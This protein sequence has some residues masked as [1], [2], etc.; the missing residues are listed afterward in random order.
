MTKK[1]LI[2]GKNSY[3]GRSF[4]EYCARN[5]IDFD[6][7]EL[8]VHGDDWKQVGFSRF[9]SVFHVAGI[10]HNS[11][12]S[13]LKD[14]YY[15]VNRDLTIAIAEKAKQDG[16][17]QFIFM[18]SMI[19]FGNQPNGKT[20]ITADTEPNPDNFYGDSKLQAERGLQE[21]ESDEFKV[22]VLRPPMIYGEG[23]KGNYPLLSKFAQ[24]SPVFPDYPNK[25]S[26]LYIDNLCEFVK[27]MILNEENGTFHPQNKELVQTSEMV[28]LIA[29]HH[30][31]RIW[32]T[33]LGNPLIR[34][35]LKINIIKK[36]FGSLY[37]EPSMSQYPKGKYQIR[38]LNE[39]IRYTERGSL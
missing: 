3:V 16:V 11:S 34:F 36:V 20:K 21:L 29:E 10:A 9:D 4:I 30:K 7:S 15:E 39:S 12:D 24:R 38:S 27:L 19:V 33:K 2:T 22:V 5:S 14:L 28:R 37:Y 32:F 8:D 25:R 6:I 26:M 17:Q 18:S 1:I 35:L 31:H 13:N 23:S